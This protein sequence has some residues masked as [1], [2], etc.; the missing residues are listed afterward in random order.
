[1]LLFLQKCCYNNS[2]EGVQ[3]LIDSY[4]SK[5]VPRSEMHK[6]NNLYRQKRT[7]KEMRLSAQ[8]GEYD[9]DHAILDMGYEANVLT[10]Q[11]WEL[12]G[13][14]KLQWSPIQL[15]MMNQQKI[16]PLGRL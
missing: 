1:M 9:M 2:H 10:K 6:V 4:A 12:R 8:I 7:G 14:P 16:V 11:I 15:R 3:E 13:K 5:E